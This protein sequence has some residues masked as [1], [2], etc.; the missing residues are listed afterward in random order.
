MAGNAASRASLHACAMSMG[1]GKAPGLHPHTASV[2][3][4]RANRQHNQKVQ[5][6]GG[7]Q[8]MCDIPQRIR[9]TE[10]VHKNHRVDAADCHELSTIS[11][12]LPWWRTLETGGI[13]VT[14]RLRR[15]SRCC[16]VEGAVP[17]VG[18]HGW[19]HEQRLAEVPGTDDA[20]DKVVTEPISLHG[21]SFRVPGDAKSGNGSWRVQGERWS[22]WKAYIITKRC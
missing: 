13:T 17:H 10:H 14:P 6:A 21:K 18:V 11:C 15:V 20:C 12:Q 9:R 19:C 22:W 3:W 8:Q 5:K 1:A 16:D 4:D 2:C 7:D